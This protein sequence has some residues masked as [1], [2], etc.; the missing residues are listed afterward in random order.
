MTCAGIGNRVH[1]RLPALDMT[2]SQCMPHLVG[3]D[4]KEVV[5]SQIV[6][7]IDPLLS[8]PVDVLPLAEPGLARKLSVILADQLILLLEN[9][10]QLKLMSLNSRSCLVDLPLMLLRRSR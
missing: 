2:Q 5:Q 3:Q 10:L 4:P 9:L 1:D 7:D 6:V 8:L